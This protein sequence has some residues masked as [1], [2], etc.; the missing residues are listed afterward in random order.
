M[1]QPMTNFALLLGLLG[2]RARDVVAE[3]GAD[4]SLVSR[5]CNGK[6]KLMPGHG[7]VD[8]VADYLLALDD[9]LKM[10]VIPGVL[11]AYYPNEALRSR[12]RQR[13]ALLD[14]L[15]TVGH[16]PPQQQ[17]D[18]GLAG[19]VL[20]KAA[21][22][23]APP[24]EEPPVAPP[25]LKGVVVQGV[26][27]VQGGALQFI[28][29]ICEQPEP[30]DVWYVCPEGL[31]MYTRDEK[32]AQPF[33]QALMGMFEAGHTLNVVLR[34]DYKMTD[35]SAFSG[36]WLVAH[37]LGYVK[38]HYF[39]DFHHSYKDKM[40]AVVEGKMAMRVV[41]D[42][43]EGG[44]RTAIHFDTR[45][46]AAVW[47]EIESYRSR[48]RQRFHYELFEHP[49]GFLRGIEP[50]PDRVHYR[51]SRVPQFVLPNCAQNLAEYFSLTCEES[52]RVLQEFGPL[53]A[54][55]DYF[56]APVHHIFCA[57]DIDDT[58]LKERHVVQALSGICG[59]RVN[60]TTQTF[61]NQLVHM[62]SLLQT[63]RNYEV[64]FLPVE[65][66]NKI[67]IQIG[68]WGDRAAVGWVAG[69]RSTACR[70]YT[71]V[72]A[73]TGFC[74]MVWGKIPGVMK[75]RST[76]IRKLNTWLKKADKYGYSVGG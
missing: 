73:L 1:A 67:R 70:D 68:C 41:D 4:K 54:G 43:K 61:V 71:N 7:W 57:D 69:G 32:F 31:E 60:M 5:W 25:P 30:Q 24:R 75:R 58:L 34:T 52:A 44:I 8:K 42:G 40:L 12:A 46:V 39:D 10:P 74:E 53:M 76:A 38:S 6:Q 55:P 19:L 65:H 26:A 37:L 21:P 47:K 3:V 72:N 14:W 13:A 22:F 56:D 33:M 29:L 48:S 2:A 9:R 49:D 27:G 62:R 36:P 59:R 63:Q 16:L 64:C 15:C 20:E 28:E 50:L 18:A 35:V 23:S 45:A 17:A 11:A 66:F 51:F